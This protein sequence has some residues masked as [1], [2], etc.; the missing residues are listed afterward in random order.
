VGGTTIAKIKETLVWEK[1]A[2][3]EHDHGH[4]REAIASNQHLVHPGIEPV[5][6]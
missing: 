5:G 2:P 6:V 1:L 4:G 3:G